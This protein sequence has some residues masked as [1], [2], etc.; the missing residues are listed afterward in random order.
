VTATVICVASAKGGAGKTVLTATFGAFLAALD[1]RV[2]LVDTDAATNG[3][4]LMYLGET[5]AQRTESLGA[6]GRPS[7]LYDVARDPFEPDHGVTA[8]ALGNGVSM[9]PATYNL[10]NT[11]SVDPKRFKVHLMEVLDDARPNYDFVF[12]DAQAG[13]DPMAAIS[14]A[15]DVSD[16]VLIVSEYDPLSV[17]GVERLKALFPKELSY[18]RTWILLNKMLP[19]F[20]QSFTD[21]MEVAR[22][23][24]PIPWDADVVRAYARRSLALDLE[25]GNDFTLA[26]T[27]TL[28]GLLGSTMTTEIDSW[29]A[30]RAAALREP[31]RSQLKDVEMELEGL[32]LQRTH[33]AQRV[34][35]TRLALRVGSV[36]YAVASVWFISAFVYRSLL[37]N[38]AGQI[39]AFAMVALIASAIDSSGVIRSMLMILGLGRS[40][41]TEA[42]EERRRQRRE[43]VLEARLKLLEGLAEAHPSELLRSPSRDAVT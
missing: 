1:K 39:L 2:L 26:V 11:E 21:F 16:R 17:A 29:L 8:I 43:E 31:I 42:V 22:Y 10:F 23:L 4:T 30:S 32:I 24:S 41:A 40:D 36:V 12:L 6:D 38:A 7:G 3:L 35:R 33:G 9:V 14:M 20:I 13:S 18:D 34:A 15:T 5:I 28:K 25:H 19:E 37:D 27:Q